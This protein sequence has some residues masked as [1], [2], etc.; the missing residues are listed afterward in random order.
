MF[1]I[2][3]KNCLNKLYLGLDKSKKGSLDKDIIPLIKLINKNKDCYSTSSCSGRIMLYT[4]SKKK[5]NSKWLYVTHNYT[6]ENI[7]EIIKNCSE[8]IWFKQESF[9]LHLCVRDLKTAEKIIELC[10]EN[11]IKKVGIIGIKNKITIE[12]CYH[13]RFDL[14]LFKEKL[15]VNE[16]YIKM[17]I[18]KANDNMKNNKE[19]IKA[20]TASFSTF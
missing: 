12:I 3:K 15:L 14:P 5:Y 16:E 20:F 4:R 7:I 2:D 19:K 10:H 13:I 9:I 11:G 18:Q 6:D 1:D 8:E 17:I